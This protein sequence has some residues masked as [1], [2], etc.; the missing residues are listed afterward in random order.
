MCPRKPRVVP[1][2][3]RSSMSPSR[4]NATTAN[5]TSLRSIVRSLDSPTPS[6]PSPAR[7]ASTTST[8][9]TIKM[10]PPVGRR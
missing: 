3:S 6:A 9:S 5:S 10:P 4:P 1:S 2:P 7:P 8:A